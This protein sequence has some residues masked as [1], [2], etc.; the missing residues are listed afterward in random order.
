VTGAAGLERGYRR[1][2]ACYPA[3]FRSQHGEELLA[4]LLAGARDGQ[5][6]PGLADSASLL[7]S[8]LGMRL[9][10]DVSRSAR[11]GWADALAVF[12]LAGPVLLLTTTL[13][14]TP[15]EV[16]YVWRHLPLG[17][18]HPHAQL[19]YVFGRGY[20]AALLGSPGFWI[21]L[22]FQVVV[23][24]L[25]LAGLR[26]AALVMTAAAGVYFFSSYT[27][28]YLLSFVNPWFPGMLRPL[29]ISVCIVELAA[30]LGSPGPRRGRDLVHWG[31]GVVLL[32]FAVALAGYSALLRQAARESLVTLLVM[33]IVVALLARLGR[34]AR[35]S[36]Y[37]RLLLAALA[38]PYVL[39]Q[40]RVAFN[41]GWF[42][43][44]TNHGWP[45]LLFA[46][47]VLAAAVAVISTVRPRRRQII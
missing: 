12:S 1:L 41:S 5:R 7:R 36:R 32:L 42:Y 3:R 26:R 2:L 24:A 9:R 44:L 4:V 27:S 21:T 14:G 35:L 46:G 22:G 33:V 17:D 45:A 8:G 37:F 18:V 13:L 30:L 20:L 19:A 47:P 34:A 39:T 16:G 31:H 15:G 6:R 38:Y 40:A 43:D 11:Q 25:V 10:P 28:F 23:A 29:A